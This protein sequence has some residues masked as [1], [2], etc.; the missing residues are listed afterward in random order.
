MLERGMD[1]TRLETLDNW[2]V[3]TWLFSDNRFFMKKTIKRGKDFVFYHIVDYG[4]DVSK[5]K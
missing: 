5:K 3:R 1:A 2:N 4:M